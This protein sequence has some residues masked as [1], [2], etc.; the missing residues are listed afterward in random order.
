MSNIDSRIVSMQF[1]NANFERKLSDTLKSLDQLNR[2]LELQNSS[3]GMNELASATRS[4]DVSH[5]AAGI[6]SVSSKFIALSTIAITTL[7]NITTRAISAGAQFI[8]S[9]SVD[10]ILQGFREFETN[11]NSIQ[12]ILSNTDSKGT[13]LSQVNGALDELN[14][15]SDKTIYNFSE[16][17]RNI[18]TF[19]AAGVDLDTATASIKGIANLAA[20][21]GSNSQQAATAMYQLSQAIAAGSV[22]LMDWNSVV[23]AGMGGEVFQKALFET[24]KAMGTLANVP[25]DQSFEQWKDAGNSFRSSLSGTG[26]EVESTADKVAK[27]TQES[28]RQIADAEESAASS[29]ESANERVRAARESVNET[30]KSS[31]KAVADAEESKAEAAARSAERIAQAEENQ[32]DI[33]EQTAKDVARA[34]EDQKETL[35]RNAV[36]VQSAL[37][38]VTEA[39]E[40]L[41]EAMKPESANDLEAATDR[42]T[43]AQL[44]QADLANAIE[45]AERN[46]QRASEDL[47]AAQRALASTDKTSTSDMLSARR[48]V[49]DAEERVRDL[50]DA[51]ERARLRQNDATRSV[52]EAE[53]RLEQAR[54]KG[55]ATDEGVISAQKALENA[56]KNLVET[57][58]RAAER[59]AEAAENL[60]NAELRSAEQRTNA[61]ELL[62]EA[63]AEATKSALDQ[64]ER[65]A[66]VTQSSSKRQA[67][68]AKALAD[69]EKNAAKTRIDAQ[70]SIT[71]A[72]ES[73]AERMAAANRDAGGMSDPTMGW[74]TGDVLTKT[75]SAFT[76]DLDEVQLR[77]MGYTKEQ[78]AEMIRLGQIGVAAAQ[79]VKTLTQ[80]IGTVK[81]T[82]ASGWSQSFRVIV[83]DFEESK[84]LFTGINNAIGAM[85]G[86]SAHA[87]NEMLLQWKDFGGRDAL[88]QGFK[89]AFDAIGD[90]LVRVREAFHDVFPK[91]T[92]ESLLR[93]TDS[94][95]KFTE[96]LKM[97]GETLRDIKNVFRGFFS[98]LSIG[99]EIIKGI[100]GLIGDLLSGLSPVGGGFLDAASDAGMFLYE[101]QQLLV[102][103]GAIKAFFN[104]IGRYVHRAAEFFSE[105]TSSV[106]S[107]FGEFTT[108]AASEGV[109][110][111]TDRFGFLGEV[112]GTA[113]RVL[114][115]LGDRFENLLNI[116]DVVWEHL[117][118]WFSDLGQRLADTMG[119]GDFDSVL[120]LIN[121]GLFAGLVLMFR[122][123]VNNGF[124]FDIGEGLVAN[125]TGAVE[126]LTGTLSAMQRDIQ[127]KTLMK[128][129][130]AVAILT[131]S[132]VALS[133][134]DDQ[135]LAKAMTAIAIGFGQ[136]MSAMVLMSKLNFGAGAAK[137]VA[138]VTG[139]MLLSG[140]MILLSV[141]VKNLSSLGWEELAKGLAGTYAMLMMLVAAAN[142]ISANTAG[143]I[144]AGVAMTAMSVGIL[145][146]SQA[147]KAF[148]EMDWEV[149]KQ[150]LTGVGIALGLLV[151][152]LNLM[153]PGVILM[154]PGL[155]AV[156]IAMGLLAAAVLAFGSIE[157]EVMKRGFIGLG[158]GLLIVAAAMN[159]MPITLPII[160]AGMLLLVPALVGMA[161]ALKILGTMKWDEIGR[162]LAALGG[163]LL[164]LAIGVNAMSYA[165]GGA[166]AMVIVAG[167]LVVLTGVLKEL[168]Q[169]SMGELAMGLGAIAGVMLVLGASALFL[170]PLL[171]FLLGLGAA[172]TLVGASFALFGVG[173]IL[174][175]KALELISRAGKAGIEVVVAAIDT[176]VTALPRWVGGLITALLRMAAEII[177]AIPTV[178]DALKVLL[179]SLLD[180]IVEVVPEIVVAL[181]AIL[182]GLYELIKNNVPQIIEIGFVILKALLQG[183]R[184]NIQNILLVGIEILEKLA[185]T[186]K[187]NMSRIVDAG[188]AILLAFLKS[189]SDRANDIV[190]AGLSLLTSFLLGITNNVVIIIN[191]VT[192]IITTILTELAD[193]ALDIVAAGVSI[194]VELM[195]G[196]SD[197]LNL[198]VD[199]VEDMITEFLDSVGD[200][201]DDILDAGAE[202]LEEFLKGISDNIGDIVDTVGDVISRFI[203]ELALKAKD[204]SDAG[205]GA[206]ESFI[207][208]FGKDVQSIIDT[209]AKVVGEILTGLGSKA[210]ELAQ[211][212]G[213][214]I[215]DFLNGI[216]EWIRTDGWQIRDAGAN[217]IR[218]LIDGMTW[219][220][221]SKLEGFLNDIGSFMQK[222]I[223][224]AWEVIEPGSPSKVG[225][226]M[227]ENLAAGLAQGLD[228]D[229]SAQN[230]AVAMAESI[231][232]EFEKTL[233]GIPEILAD[234]DEMNPVI[235]PVLD[236]TRVRAEA[237]DLSR[238]MDVSSLAPAGSYAR[239][240]HISSTTDV[241][242]DGR[243]SSSRSE[244]TEV[245]FTQTI[246]APKPLSTKDIYRNT[247]GLIAKAKEELD[248]S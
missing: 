63:R 167:A 147:V 140:A 121:T 108:T 142:F 89:N 229:T 93:M 25:I 219:G 16:M 153:P 56:Q 54:A 187:A 195:S 110:R 155:V 85:V 1:D 20:L 159:L 61:I 131:V 19:T 199:A 227:T 184:D 133:M 120:S 65:L 28:S 173:A 206:L 47:A 70:E 137:L 248:I 216:A 114:E 95:V 62:A 247:K 43:T 163:M 171:P 24:G 156:S 218:A 71:R 81:E 196:I 92:T 94:F 8:K 34:V 79:D 107:F 100:L 40:R 27:A 76:G 239:A 221:A 232:R 188:V 6:E 211:K 36:D 59:E 21:S 205:A 231:V 37:D 119:A 14:H 31:A 97:G 49:E 60:K 215:V 23:N 83:G 129:A 226:R 203:W 96:K 220:L 169:L 113:G 190:G 197:N 115:W 181:G 117:S 22:K 102:E 204:L 136:L 111:V 172:L 90:V 175:A 198:V 210:L 18:G 150:G 145:I 222:G 212:A 234:L 125:L 185:K 105:F 223:D 200:N 157:W 191:T 166:V 77:A 214:V 149:M 144:R 116:L 246:N 41:K 213:Q 170:A 9:F 52:A 202:L 139:M 26:S 178:L 67:D 127:A 57:R 69:A 143:M 182:K 15:Y 82:V 30:A 12:T 126:Q 194:L 118:G 225:R 132:I 101:M 164:L 124:K 99:W 38:A 207:E 161:G 128:I 189:I 123:F 42:L 66:E 84:K 2:S 138:M 29:I 235:T 237:G 64:E 112:A 122:R 135:A 243:D 183:I 141:A 242:E 168:G 238:L 55:S 193:A 162:G 32:A 233:S 245:T 87:R 209:G 68:A 241:V 148:G 10:P 44:D 152:A 58:E 228:K 154:G 88:I 3:R 179:L 192:F 33:F 186:L 201:L 73:A 240:S 74:L 80:L 174:I 72:R 51:V 86:D 39:Q 17:A 104:N 134:I 146:L 78:A 177:L 4:L 7:A 46:Q 244:P 160:A 13:T 5:I 11:M 208:G 48:R 106:L 165:V 158:G 45:E 130:A 98:I 236:L 103:G 151:L 75:L 109:E 35:E 91:T 53:E 217:I 50:A 224:K 180:L 176:F 230:S